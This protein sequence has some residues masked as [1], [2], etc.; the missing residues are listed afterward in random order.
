MKAIR[1]NAF[2]G[3]EV[4]RL[5]EVE[6]PVPKADE[7]LVK[8]YASGVNPADYV[9]R[10]GGNAILKPLLKLPLGLGI[11]GAGIVEAI[12]SDVHTL[13]VGDPVYGI[14]NML[15]GT[16]QEYIA[17]KAGQFAVKPVNLSF[18]EAGAIPSCALMAWD[19]MYLGHVGSGKRVL[20]HG[21]SGGIGSLA[22]QFAKAK[23]AYVIGTC[24]NRN[25]GLVK[26]LG[27]DEAIAY[28]DPHFVALLHNLDTVLDASSVYNE[29]NRLVMAKAL[30]EGGKFLSVQLPHAFS[31]ALLEILSEKH[32]EAKMIRRD[33]DV[34][35]ALTDIAALIEKGAVKVT[36]SKV[37]PLERA[38]EALSDLEMKNVR[39]KIALEI[40]KEK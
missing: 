40:S 30:N 36:V 31:E 33:L 18:I 9:V 26:Q 7:V 14:P 4:M 27:A 8:M 35:K 6:R 1:I 29:E 23:G 11:D 25:L 24:S 17:A 15:Q 21:A 2:G 16:Y 20:V 32:A 34:A 3:P 5:E 10:N 28:D 38:T 19:G 13:K 37:Y 39:G 12:G 22:L